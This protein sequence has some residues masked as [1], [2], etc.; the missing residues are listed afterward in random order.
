VAAPDQ[1]ATD[2][3]RVAVPGP[4]RRLWSYSVPAGLRDACRPGTRVLVPFG[5]RRVTGVVVGKDEEPGPD[6]AASYDIKPVERVLDEVP[7]LDPDLLELTRWAAE[8]YGAS[9]G[10]MIRTALPGQQAT[11]RFEAA[12]T[13]AG[14][15]RLGNGAA[16]P[17]RRGEA[18]AAVAEAAGA[19]GVFVSLPEIRRRTGVALSPAQARALAR[20]GL[21]AVRESVDRPGPLARE[22]TW[23]V[24]RSPPSAGRR[25]PGARQKAVLAALDAAPDGLSDAAL[26]AATGASAGTIHSLERLGLLRLETRTAP[27]R[28]P[29]SEPGRAG[30]TETRPL[31]PTAPQSDALAAVT[32]AIAARRF[33]TF[34]LF[35]VTGSGK[36]EVYLRAVEAVLAA[37]RSALYLVPEIGLTPLLARQMRERFGE[38]LALFHSGLTEGERQDAWRDARE[39]RVRVVLGAR[40]A[41]FAPLPDPGL[42]IVDEEH[43]TSYKQDEHPRYNGRDLAIVRARA[44]NAVVLLG[45]AT[46]SV[47]SWSRAGS[48]KSRLLRLGGRVGGAALPLVTRVDMRREF[49]ETGRET[50]LSRRLHHALEERLRRG[51]QSLVLL[52]RRGFST[53]AVCRACGKPRECGQC[54]IG[55]TLHRREN[56]LRCHYCNA[57][58]R[59]PAQCPACGGGPMH[60]GGTGTERLEETIRS[61]FPRARV[62]RMDRDTVRG[63]GVAERLLLQVERG[64]VDILLGTQMIAKG[65]DFPNVT[66]VGVLA[67]DALLGFPD[68]RAGERTFQLLAQVAGRSG[69]RATPGE[70]IVQ[71]FDPDHHAVRAACEHDYEGFAREEL[72]YRRAL[73]YPPYS[74]LALLVFRDPDY[75]AAHAAAGRIA[76]GLRAAGRAG[77]QILGPAPAPL[78]RLRGQWRVQVL[79]KGSRRAAVQAALQDAAAR[80]EEAGLRPD[81]VGI[82]VDPV[83]TL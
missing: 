64:E 55:L 73:H 3:V 74:A 14:Y 82:D 37:G 76:A 47:E 28:R 8:Y 71:A 49:Q 6:A 33:E 36:T 72:R 51:E 62:V 46:P 9:W 10:E 78:E 81:A 13:V 29:P 39:G 65:H 24:R 30:G 53:F 63:R 80:I 67:G 69:R 34:L 26:R 41:V 50:I 1:P 60:F 2:R 5:G 11:L 15:E 16:S 38:A 17:S 59:V 79:I 40:S 66:L 31:T 21:L 44:R 48:G 43:D 54:S 19:E 35:G 7:A 20:A 12:L 61:F 45:S 4:L 56:R 42:V 32:E 22:E 58:E 57:S 70:V 25:G 18:L 75:E 77:V 23:V 68:F 83:S 27:P 52:N